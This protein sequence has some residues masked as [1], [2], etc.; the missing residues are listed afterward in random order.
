MKAVRF[1]KFSSQLKFLAIFFA[2]SLVSSTFEWLQ[3]ITTV[4]ITNSSD[5]TIDRID[6][7]FH[8]NGKFQGEIGHG[9][10][11]GKTMVFKWITEGEASYRLTASFS[12]GTVIMG[13][14]GYTERGRATEESFSKD[15][16]MST[17]SYFP[18][19]GNTSDTTDRPLKAK[20][21]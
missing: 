21:H 20:W 7:E 10:A 15:K 17:V 1:P 13:G 19:M 18:F 16:V 2:G 5:L 8:G 3:P 12:D 6:V 11:P 4:E 14:A 9:L